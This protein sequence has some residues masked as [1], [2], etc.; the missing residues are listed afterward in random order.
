MDRLP[1]HIFYRLE[2]LKL[3]P[4]PPVFVTRSFS[5][6]FGT[7]WESILEPT[8]IASTMSIPLAIELNLQ[9]PKTSPFKILLSP[10]EQLL[11]IT[12]FAAEALKLVKACQFPFFPLPSPN[13]NN[14]MTT[15]TSTQ[16]DKAVEIM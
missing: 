15:Y 3:A 16:F 4:V 1:F 2:E 14:I 12:T 10:S 7:K 13:N 9:V 5:L 6:F 11:T 8:A